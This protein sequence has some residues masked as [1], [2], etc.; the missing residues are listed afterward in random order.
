MDHAPQR[1]ALNGWIPM[2]LLAVGLVALKDLA[3]HGLAWLYDWTCFWVRF[4]YPDPELYLTVLPVIPVAH[5]IAPSPGCLNAGWFLLPVVFLGIALTAGVA[6]QHN[7]RRRLRRVVW[8]IVPLTFGLLFLR[9]LAVVAY[10]HSWW[11]FTYYHI[12]VPFPVTVMNEYTLGGI[13]L[14]DVGFLLWAIAM[15]RRI[16]RG[17]RAPAGA[18]E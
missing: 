3:I 11:P 4:G 14:I 5:Q 2:L 8:I 7:E 13:F 1:W 9:T 17:R 12:E 18:H 16:T 15:G 10:N 6:S